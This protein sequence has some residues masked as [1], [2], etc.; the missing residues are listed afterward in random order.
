MQG[1]AVAAGK[2]QEAGVHHQATAAAVQAH[3]DATGARRGIK[4]ETEQDGDPLGRGTWQG[5]L[6]GDPVSPASSCASALDPQLYR[7]AAY[8]NLALPSLSLA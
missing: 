5:P 6:D 2:R 8:L 1:Q 7:S 3:N 4:G